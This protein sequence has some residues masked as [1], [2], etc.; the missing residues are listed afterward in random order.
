MRTLKKKI[1]KYIISVS[2]DVYIDKLD[3]IVNKYSNTYYSP[4]KMKPLDVRF[5]TYNDYGIENNV[6]SPNFSWCPCKNIKI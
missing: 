6:R 2:K 5:N 4:T 1:Y 3:D